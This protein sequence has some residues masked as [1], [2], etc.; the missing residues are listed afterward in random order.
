MSNPIE[1]N[2]L[3]VSFVVNFDKKTYKTTYLSVHKE[4]ESAEKEAS[5]LKN[6]DN[7]N[8]TVLNTTVNL[9]ELLKDKNLSPSE[10]MILSSGK[11]PEIDDWCLDQARKYN[12]AKT[13]KFPQKKPKR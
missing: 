13:I 11:F 2:H 4:I 9:V 10:E 3:K 5:D 8:A 6:S 7:P 12:E 1:G